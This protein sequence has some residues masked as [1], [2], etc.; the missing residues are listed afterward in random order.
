[1][2]LSVSKGRT[3]LILQRFQGFFWLSFALLWQ[4][5]VFVS[6][7]G[8]SKQNHL[9]LW[10]QML[11][12]ESLEQ[13]TKGSDGLFTLGSIHVKSGSFLACALVLGFS[14]EKSVIT[15]RIKRGFG[16]CYKILDGSM[17]PLGSSK[18]K[19]WEAVQIWVSH[20]WQAKT[21][22]CGFSLLVGA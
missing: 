3:N 21:Q 7:T 11:Q 8:S 4:T 6:M 22:W 13:T 9:D 18:G 19:E 15:L 17:Q 14:D 2:L 16:W 1:M 5:L 12:Q 20:G 10:Q